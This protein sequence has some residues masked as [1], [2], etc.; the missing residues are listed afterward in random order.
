MR[1]LFVARDDFDF[2][3]MLRASAILARPTDGPMDPD[4]QGYRRRATEMCNHR[5][6]VHYVTSG[7]DA[8]RSRRWVRH[9]L[10]TMSSV[11]H[12][13][14]DV[15]GFRKP[16]TDGKRGG[17]SRFDVYL[18]DLG[19]RGLFGYCTP[20]T[21]VA[22]QQY[23]AS[24]YCVLDNDFA[25]KQ[26]DARPEV[27]LEVTAAH[28]FF[29]AIQFGYD[30]RADPWLMES[31]AV[32]M[33]ESFADSANDN[34]RYLPYGDVAKPWIPLDKYSD[35]GYSQYGNWAFWQFL[36][37]KYG[38]SL[39]RQ[40]W[41]RVDAVDG[42]P[43][44]ASVP[45]LSW[46]LDRRTHTTTGL[47]DALA[48]YAVANL[49]P[50]AHYP[51][52]KAWPS[53]ALSDR[54]RLRRDGGSRTQSVVVDHL[55]ARNIAFKPPVKGSPRALVVTVDTP[56]RRA[57]AVVTVRRDDG[58]TVSRRI[59]LTKGHGTTRVG[60]SPAS[61]KSVVVTLVNTSARYDC[62]RGTLLS[63]GGMALDDHEEFTV[64]A[65]VVPVAQRKH[66]KAH[67]A[68]G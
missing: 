16:P 35:S 62:H 40:V 24:G 23:A 42:G 18:S 19:S 54:T 51:E 12:H 20:E 27:S 53:A 4:G 5:I 30:Y 31:T 39:I 9:T 55:A 58:R 2:F 56:R 8:P 21:Q 14:I 50:A 45:A 3:T 1:D 46:A 13:E 22:G 37:D 11:W 34:R 17:D 41:S 25:K 59:T 29:H 32:W 67:R 57:A 64:S 15:L 49:D 6:C 60:F 38:A 7:S 44:D 66:A 43:A 36:T 10:R 47:A 33:E 68:R 65:E 26:Y 63:C 61:V 48:A 28:E 52:G